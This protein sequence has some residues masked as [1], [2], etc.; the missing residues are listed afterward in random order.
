[1]GSVKDI[2]EEMREEY[3]ASCRDHLAGIQG[4]L[5]DSTGLQADGYNLVQ[6]TVHSI[7]GSAYTFGL[8]EM[9]VLCAAWES[10]MKRARLD[11]SLAD[12]LLQWQR[13]AAI[14]AALLSGAKAPQSAVPS[15]GIT[16]TALVWSPF[17]SNR[18]AL[19]PRAAALATTVVVAATDREALIAASSD[20]VSA[21]V[22]DTGDDSE[23]DAAGRARL[24]AAAAA[25]LGVPW[26]CD[27]LTPESREPFV[28]RGAQPL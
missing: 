20:N 19:R 7:K 8:P 25:G 15:D 22:G 1:M 14:Y 2:V 3:L 6:R 13:F 27:R 4:M 11:D 18:A 23:L 28:A 12:R 9:S 24:V 5:D 21:I 26:Y 10:Q 17:A 16:T